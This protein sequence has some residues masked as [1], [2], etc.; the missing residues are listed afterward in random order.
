M[1][2]RPIRHPGNPEGGKFDRRR[3][4][5]HAEDAELSGAE[6][7]D[8]F[9]DRGSVEPAGHEHAAG[10]R[11]EEG[12]AAGDGAGEDLGGLAVVVCREGVGAGR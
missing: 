3:T 6:G 7:V 2:I 4:S 10:S 5:G 8:Q 12:P 11:I 9:A 1:G